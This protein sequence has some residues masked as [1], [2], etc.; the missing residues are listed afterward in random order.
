MKLQ[1]IKLIVAGVG[2]TTC[3]GGLGFAVL[4][5]GNQEMWWMVLSAALIL[6]GILTLKFDDRICDAI[7]IGPKNTHPE[8]AYPGASKAHRL[9]DNS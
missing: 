4:M 2:L 9:A 1:K 7:G 5:F 6:V 3:L 8:P